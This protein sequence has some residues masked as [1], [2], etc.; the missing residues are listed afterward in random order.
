MFERLFKHAHA[1]RRHRTPPLVEE[2][3]L[4]LEHLEEQQMTRNS[5]RSVAHYL[6]VICD[7][8][9]LSGRADEV[10]SAAEIVT[11][12]ARWACRPFKPRRRRVYNSPLARAQF[13]RHATRWL[14]FLGRLKETPAPPVVCGELMAAFAD[15]MKSERGL[16]ER[17]VELRCRAV[18]DFLQRIGASEVSLARVTVADVLQAL[19]GKVTEGRYARRT[20]Q[21]YAS[22][23]RVFLRYAEERG[24]CRH[25]LST[26]IVSP[27]VFRHEQLPAGPSWD[28]VQQLLRSVEGD[29]P[30]DI[31]DRAILLLLVVYGLRNGEIVRLCLDDFDWEQELL[32]V[33]RPK[34]REKA[35]YPLSYVVGDAVL[36]Y[37]QE[38]RPRAN[39]REVFLTLSAPFRPLRTG[40]WAIVASRLGPLGVS[41]PHHGPHALRHACAMRLLDRGLSLKEIGDHLGH[42]DPDST[43][44]YAKVDLNGLRRVADFDLGG[45]Q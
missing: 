20:V 22:G 40:L 10:I 12:A 18:G 24:W 6:L 37:L 2:R 19:E 30:A 45:L 39:Y 43:R 7:R 32:F 42:R 13:T 23:V 35:Q 5:L 33:A 3:L 9:S 36:R 38:I 28:E 34:T 26:A 21:I 31:R 44:I 27:R 17:T 16:S 25:G 41:I 29:R 15:H 8:L 1:V 4:Y 11:A 14:R